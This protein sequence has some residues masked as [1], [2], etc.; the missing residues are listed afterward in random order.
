MS[1]DGRS[2]L[3][4]SRSRGRARSCFDWSRWYVFD[5]QNQMEGRRLVWANTG[6]QHIHQMHQD[7][8]FEYP[9]HVEHLGYTDRCA[10]QGMYVKKRV[11]TVQGH[12]EFNGNIV[13]ELLER[14]HSQ[15]IFND[16][17]YDEGMSRVRKHHDGVRI[18]AA[19]VRF[20]MEE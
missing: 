11:I 18:G 12:P 9:A 20:C 19:F 2:L 10:V 15:G 1:E 8:V 3:F 13:A 7:I 5:T 17:M 6:T 4:L 16:E 14:R